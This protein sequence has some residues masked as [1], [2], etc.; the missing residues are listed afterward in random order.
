MEQGWEECAEAAMTH[1]LRTSL[2]KSTK[3]AVG[4]STQ[5]TALTDTGKLKKH[6]GLVCERLARGG[7]LN[8]D[9]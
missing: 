7:R 1:L 6:I 3:E 2:A 5:L 8:K 9:K 4:L